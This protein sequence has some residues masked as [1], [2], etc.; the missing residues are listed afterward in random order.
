MT[1]LKLG[2]IGCGSISTVSHGPAAARIPHLVQFTACCDVRTEA[3][4]TWGRQFGVEC[5]YT[6][7]EEMIR[8][9]EL[10]GV[11]LA[12]WPNQH[13]DQVERLL[14]AGVQNIL[15]EKSLCLTGQDA[16]ALYQLTRM[17]GAF[18]MEGFMYRH[19][20][21]IRSMQSLLDTGECGTVDAVRACFSA[22]D[23]ETADANNAQRDWRQRKECGGGI[24]YD[25]A[26]YAVNSCGCF[27][28]SFPVRAFCVGDI[29]EKYDTINRMYG[30]I[31]YD[32]GCVGIIESSKKA[33]MSQELEVTGSLKSL[34]LPVA[35]TIPGDITLT[36]KHEW[37]WPR[38]AE[39]A[40]FIHEADA[41]Q[42]QL[43]NFAAV[44][45]GDA[46]QVVSLAQS[47]MNIYTLEALVTSLLEKREVAINI[48]ADIIA[49]AREEIT[50]A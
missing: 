12:T 35:W 18:L 44:I 27:S 25:F 4:V 43:E 36:V 13:R 21:A 33:T 3:A 50:C 29:S 1:P 2:L 28:N 23:A 45:R 42:L 20:P 26:C 49:A 34:Y 10:D 11:L 32:N 15:C 38:P 31:V 9:E 47:V 39:D 14:A 17:A 24:P 30:M 48:P 6:D 37:P 7:Y 16:H 19:H 5:V 22:H 41:Y 8:E 40:I 46:R